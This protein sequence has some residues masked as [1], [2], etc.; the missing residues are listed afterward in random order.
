M[1]YGHHARGPWKMGV[2]IAVAVAAL[3]GLAAAP[4]FATPP[5]TT[6]Q[7]SPSS[8]AITYGGGVIL[9][10]TL[11][12]GQAA[13]GGKW[14]ELQQGTTEAGS[15]QVLQMVTTSEG[16][17]STGQ[18]SLAVMPSRTTYYRF[19]W[20]GDADYAAS[21]SDVVPVTVKPALSKPTCPSSVK[22]GTKFTVQG[23]VKPGAPDGPAVKIKSYRKKSNGSWVGYKTYGAK[24][25][26]TQY[27]ATFAINDTGTFKFK[28]STADSASFAAA[29]S[30]YSAVI[31]VK[32]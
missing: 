19:S 17:Y 21:T 23:S 1:R 8:A 10:G 7:V 22:G 9:N 20:P 32:K 18:Y 12:S 5:A 14:V 6:W 15:F 28:A 11:T 31:T 3:I 2:V 13:V 16:A 29:L 27:K 30:S 4:A 24:G 25:S 26:G